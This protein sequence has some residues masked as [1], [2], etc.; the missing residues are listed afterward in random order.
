MSTGDMAITVNKFAR[1]ILFWCFSLTVVMNTANAIEPP[2]IPNDYLW[3]S[4]DRLKQLPTEG[5]AWKKLEKVSRRP[6]KR[7]NLSDQDDKANVEVLAKALVYAR[8]GDEN[9]REQVINSCMLAIG[10]ERNAKIG[11]AH[12]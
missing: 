4:A 2:Q 5:P 9:L 12:V 11:R 8:T 10:T 7:P 6:P 1:Q 3:I